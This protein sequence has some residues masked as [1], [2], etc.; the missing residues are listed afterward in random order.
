MKMKLILVVLIAAVIGGGAFYKLSG[1][2]KKHAHQEIKGPTETIELPE[3]VVNLADINRPHYLK[4]TIAVEVEGEGAGEKVKEVTP[5]IRD[6]V[7]T[8]LGRYMYS[9]L[10][11]AG[12][13]THL[14]QELLRCARRSLEPE[15]ITVSN[16]LI[17]AF[18]MD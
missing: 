17:T 5:H 16:V 13:K 4:I 10:L 7:I 14:R 6:A 18:V 15:E 2:G 9:T 1:A 8:V 3:F 12:G 11:T